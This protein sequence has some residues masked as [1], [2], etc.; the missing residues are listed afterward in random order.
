MALAVPCFAQNEPWRVQIPLSSNNIVSSYTNTI[1][2]TNIV[3][4]RYL[5]NARIVVTEGPSA[6]AASGANGVGITISPGF[7]FI[8]TNSQLQT[9][10]VTLNSPYAF[11]FRPDG[12]T[13][14]VY[15]TNANFSGIH[16]LRVDKLVNTSGGNVSN[17]AVY[18]YGHPPAD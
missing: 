2:V 16:T 15:T 13:N 8:G 4:P 11:T 14:V 9:N 5:E 6:I 1:A 17:L 18:I 7:L 3:L 12:Q 10:W